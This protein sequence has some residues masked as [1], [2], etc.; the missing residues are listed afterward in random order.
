MTDLFTD[1]DLSS[2]LDP[3]VKQAD[4]VIGV[5]QVSV[6]TCNRGTA[7]KTYDGAREIAFRSGTFA[8]KKY[9]EDRGENRGV[10]IHELRRI[11][12]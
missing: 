2:Y 3:P 9:F 4:A 6:L 1:F 8:L 7:T 5:D 10:H 11:R 12:R